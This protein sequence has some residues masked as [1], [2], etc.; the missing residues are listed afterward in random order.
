M[1]LPMQHILPF[2]LTPQP[3]CSASWCKE[4]KPRSNLD[5]ELMWGWRLSPPHVKVLGKSLC[6]NAVMWKRGLQ[7]TC[8]LVTGISF[9]CWWASALCKT[10]KFMYFFFFYLKCLY[11]L[12][13][14]SLLLSWRGG[15]TSKLSCQFKFVLWPQVSSI[16]YYWIL[17]SV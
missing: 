15:G 8:Y 5:L 10:S 17:T 1:D 12:A 7:V 2:P 3:L 13:I 9:H 11:F 6:T 4:R 14:G 16:M